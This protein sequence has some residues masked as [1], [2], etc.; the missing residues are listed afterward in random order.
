MANL[1]HRESI[2]LEKEEVK[3]PK[4]G[5]LG[6]RRDVQVSPINEGEHE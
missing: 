5:R 4:M 2:K 1:D 6:S 3:T